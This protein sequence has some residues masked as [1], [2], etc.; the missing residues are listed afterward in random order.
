MRL[1]DRILDA[2]TRSDTRLGEKTVAAR[3]QLATGRA[4]QRAWSAQ[5]RDRRT[6]E[7]AVR[8]E[9]ARGRDAK[10][11]D[12]EVAN[13]NLRMPFDVVESRTLGFPSSALVTF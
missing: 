13:C 10:A 3:E 9:G 1:R 4:A 11:L 8:L 12:S 5:A 7:L 6:A 2:P